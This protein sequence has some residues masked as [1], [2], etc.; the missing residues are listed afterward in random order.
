M[1]SPALATLPSYFESIDSPISLP[2]YSADAGPSEQ[3]IA[4]ALSDSPL[5]DYVSK[6][7]HIT[8]NLG[9]KLWKTKHPCYPRNGIIEG[10]VDIRGLDKVKRVVIKVNL[11]CMLQF[12]DIKLGVY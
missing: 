10:Y 8:L 12:A 3:S 5:S 4:L 6:S 1:H 11:L 9:P 2:V 7:S